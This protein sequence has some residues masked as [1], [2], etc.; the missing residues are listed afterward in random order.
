MSRWA[1]G[2]MLVAAGPALAGEV[3]CPEIPG[4]R[5]R[6]I[7]ALVLIGQEREVACDYLEAEGLPWPVGSLRAVWQEQGPVSPLS[8]LCAPSKSVPGAV[9]LRGDDRASMV[10]VRGA[11]DPPPPAWGR[12]AA[13]MLAAATARAES[14][15]SPE[16]LPVETVVHTL[17]PAEVAQGKA[18][19]DQGENYYYGRGGV[20]KSHAKALEQYMKGAALGHAGC[21][22]SVA[23]MTYHGQSIAK[24]PAQAVHWAEKAGTQGHGDA[25]DFLGDRYYYG[26]GV[27]KDYH[28]ALLWYEKGV[29]AQSPSASYS[30]GFMLERGLGTSVDLTRAL[31]LYRAAAAKGNTPAMY[32]LGMLYDQ[33]KGV[34]RDHAQALAWFRKGADKGQS[35]CLYM[36]GEMTE[37]GRGLR[38]DRAAAIAWYKKAS[39][40]GHAKAKA[41][42]ARLGA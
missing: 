27:T 30:L 38:A 2:L 4:T 5:V 11:G 19:Y 36:L 3:A 24:N 42:L 10:L 16:P 21:Q 14:C 28:V 17:T 9:V 37:K 7:T 26:Q 22:Y 8:L 39:D 32:G 18:F 35:D 41:A 13:T 25:C 20:T 34:G 33:G 29:A 40:K 1:A 23:W 6:P 12:A 15:S 31:A